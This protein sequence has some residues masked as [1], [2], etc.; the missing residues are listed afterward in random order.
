MGES[1]PRVVIFTC[2]WNAHE[3][4]QEAGKKRL[5]LPSGAR[6]LRVDCLGQVG[7]SLIL[8]AFEKGADGVMLVGCPAEECHYEFGSRRAA[9]LFEEVQKLAQLLGFRENQ[10]QFHQVH[11]GEGAA[12]IEKVRS[13]VDQLA[14]TPE[15]ATEAGKETLA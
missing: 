6:T 4:L 2:N 5:S 7:P 11:T 12:L 10:L 9:E 15:R 1:E 3:S 8:K 14:G 13:F